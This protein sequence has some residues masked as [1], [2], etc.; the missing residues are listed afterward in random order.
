M[1]PAPDLTPLRGP[2]NK[3]KVQF[4]STSSQRLYVGRGGGGV[5]NNCGGLYL[6]EIVPKNGPFL[7]H[8]NSSNSKEYRSWTQP[9]GI[10]A[11]R[12]VG[13]NFGRPLLVNLHFGPSVTPM[14]P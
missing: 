13:K 10:K 3:K 4:F 9:Q 8:G 6:R 12:Q 5:E 1:T 7:R 2:P 14:P 11:S